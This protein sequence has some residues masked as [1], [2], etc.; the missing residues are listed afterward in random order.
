MGCLSDLTILVTEKYIGEKKSVHAGNTFLPTLTLNFCFLS[1]EYYQFS[2]WFNDLMIHNQVKR[3]TALRKS[4]LQPTNFPAR[5]VPSVCT[6]LLLLI[7]S[8]EFLKNNIYMYYLC[9][10]AWTGIYSAHVE[11]RGQLEKVSSFFYHESL[12]SS[13][14]Q[15]LQ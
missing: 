11:I 4:C 3:D 8:V 7:L 12:G 15:G 9:I 6:V 2:L 10:C 13:V 5:D 1:S 14:H